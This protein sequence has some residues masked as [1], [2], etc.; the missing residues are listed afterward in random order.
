MFILDVRK[1]GLVCHHFPTSEPWSPNVWIWNNQG[2]VL[3]FKSLK[4]PKRHWID[5]NY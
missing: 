5:G 2:I 3:D 4:N 1:S